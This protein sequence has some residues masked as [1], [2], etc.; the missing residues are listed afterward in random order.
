MAK[1]EKDIETELLIKKT[2]KK[3]FF[4]DGKFNATTQ[5]IADEA[6]VNRTLINYYFRSRENLLNQVFE[7]A[8]IREEDLRQGFLESDLSFKEKIESYIDH[9]ITKAINYPYL[10]TY[11]VSRL[12]DGCFYK[13][14]EE[15]EDF[16][17]R[18]IQEFEKEVKSGNV[19]ETSPIQ[20]MLNLTS[21]ISFPFALRPLLQ[22]KMNISDEEYVQIISARKDIIM[23]ILFKK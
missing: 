10:E 7:D 20:F 8:V 13:Q 6:G 12:N 3:L 4:V 2:A 5:E 18:F 22:K 15:K 19:Q 11:I 16:L 1:K 23:K 21:L 9:A 17:N 14:E